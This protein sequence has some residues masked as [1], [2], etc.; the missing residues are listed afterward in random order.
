M[1]SVLGNTTYGVLHDATTTFFCE[2]HNAIL[3]NTLGNKTLFGKL[4]NMTLFGMS[5]IMTLFGG[6]M[7]CF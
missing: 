2:F 5:H 4:G 6:F 7:S 1:I 3:I